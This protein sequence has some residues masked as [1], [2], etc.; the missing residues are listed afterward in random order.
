MSKPGRATVSRIELRRAM[1]LVSRCVERRNTIPTLANAHLELKDGALIIQGTNVD[2]HARIEIAA[3]ADAGAAFATTVPAHTLARL[4]THLRGG[5]D[6]LTLEPGPNALRVSA[7]PNAEAEAEVVARLPALPA[8]DFPPTTTAE[9]RTPIVL[10]AATLSTWLPRLL[11]HASKEETR[12]YLNGAFFY[13]YDGKLRA[14]ATDGHRLLCATIE[15]IVP[16]AIKEALP[17]HLQK[18]AVDIHGAIVPTCFLQTAALFVA[19]AEEVSLS[20]TD[21]HVTLTRQNITLTGKLILGEY[22]NFRAIVPAGDVRHLVRMDGHALRQ[23]ALTARAMAEAEHGGIGTPILIEAK[24]GAIQVKSG[25]RHEDRPSISMRIPGSCETDG[26]CGFQARYIAQI[27]AWLG[28]E[29]EMELRDKGDP[30]VFRR[31]GDTDTLVLLMPMRVD[32]D[33]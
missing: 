21:H 27:T 7:A 6:V 10:A 30:V 20:F 26:A 1:Q 3:Q 2:L 23:A 29:I 14:A 17:L 19:N 25:G 11:A 4:A 33:I 22:P 18:G 24:G 13:Y 16:G 9:P 15:Q 8:E 31:R 5:L 32:G 12:Y 28:R